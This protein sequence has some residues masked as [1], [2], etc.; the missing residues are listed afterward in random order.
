MKFT[1]LIVFGSVIVGVFIVIAGLAQFD[2]RI[3]QRFGRGEVTVA[4]TTAL[5]A[6][7]VLL[8]AGIVSFAIG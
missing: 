1:D 6:V 5:A 8:G 3:R 4:R 2:P 7:L